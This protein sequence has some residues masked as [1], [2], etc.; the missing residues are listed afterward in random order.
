MNNPRFD[1]KIRA[2]MMQEP[3]IATDADVFSVTNS[4]ASTG[5]RRPYIKKK[6]INRCLVFTIFY[7][8]VVKS[9]LIIRDL[10]IV[11]IDGDKLIKY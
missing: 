2:I 7:D 10:I 9:K 5:I 11:R 3:T 1:Q 6:L 8:L 4:W